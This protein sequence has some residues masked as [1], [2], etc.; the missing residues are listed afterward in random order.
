MVWQT[1]IISN[2]YNINSYDM[3]RRMS[4]PVTVSL[5]VAFIAISGP[6]ATTGHQQAS[7]DSRWGETD[8]SAAASHARTKA[9]T[10][11]ITIV[12]DGGNLIAL[13][14]FDST[15]PAAANITIGKARTA[16]SFKTPTLTSEDTINKGRTSMTALR[17]CTPLESGVP[18]EVNGKAVGAIGVSGAADAQQ[19]Q[20]VALAGASAANRFASQ[21]GA[22]ASSPAAN[23]GSAPVTYSDKKNRVD[24]SCAKGGVLYPGDGHNY[25]VLTSRRDKPGQVEAHTLDA[26]VIYV[27]QGHA[28]FITR[29]TLLDGKTIGPNE[30][31]AMQLNGLK[32]PPT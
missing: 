4:P 11:S 6:C 26:D 20:E 30:I 25:Q 31:R 21:S 19:D 14:L 24:D 17:T 12:D 23:S 2:S 7:F 3:Q 28:I 8:H 1:R 5:T 22:S 32:S 27:V 13:E 18:I 15:F 16:A 9:G 29:G 10:G